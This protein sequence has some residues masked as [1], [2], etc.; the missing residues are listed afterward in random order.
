MM[1]PDENGPEEGL[2]GVPSDLFD[3]RNSPVSAFGGWASAGAG[4]GSALF[5]V[6]KVRQ[7][8]E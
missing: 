2:Q 4:V 3:G 1:A 5:A 7:A 8:V 6:T